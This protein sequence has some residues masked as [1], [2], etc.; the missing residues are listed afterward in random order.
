LSFRVSPGS[1]HGLIGENGAGKST[2]MKML[3]GMLRPD[4]GEILIRGV[5]SGFRSP[6]Q[7]IASGLGMVHQH[8][9]LAGPLTALDNI[10]IGA[11][12]MRR[13]WL[14]RSSA[15]KSIEAL[16]AEFGLAVDLDAAVETLSVGLQQRLELLKLL[17]RR[18]EILI[19]DEP[20][21]VLTPGEVRI[22]FENLKCLR[23]RGK[24]ILL[25]THKLKEVLAFTDRVTVLRNGRVSAE[26]ETRETTAMELAECMAG[27][28]VQL[29][30]AATPAA[31]QSELALSVRKLTLPGTQGGGRARLDHVSFSVHYGEIVGMAGVEGNG[32]SDLIATLLNP[33]RL[34]RGGSGSILILGQN[35]QGWSTREVR[36]LDVAVIPEDRQRDGILP[37]RP[38]SEN[39]LLGLERSK[40]FQRAGFIRWREVCREAARAFAGV[41]LQRANLSSPAEALS[42]GN[43]QKL[44]LAREL[45][46]RP[47]LILAAQPTRGID[48][49]ATQS[50]HRRILEARDAGA[51]V[52][53][54]SSDLDEVL[55]LSDR[56]L[57]MFEGRITGEYARGQATEQELGLKMGGG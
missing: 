11:E 5:R 24:T 38:L 14:D 25:V 49:G 44:V 17:Y 42:G 2:A 35:V 37:R 20:T 43:Q 28:A 56:I 41:E 3:Y 30:I 19:L 22:L 52:L 57:V 54:V 33:Q 40:R 32:Q 53:L 7:A 46:R 15:R 55:A 27:K 13:G 8:F 48:V 23:D 26:F 47:R 18:A 4:E 6:A 1:I 29:Q 10:L 36:A 21:A 34:L 16:A 45:H 39:F 9:M 50:V 12:P 51:G 31:P